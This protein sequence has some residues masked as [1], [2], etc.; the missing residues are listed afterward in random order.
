MRKTK[1]ICTIGPASESEE[2][3]RELM[4]AG[5]D[6]ARLNFSHG[7][8]AEQLAKIDAIKKVRDE[9][10]L[11]TAILLDTKGPEIRTGKFKGG[12]AILEEG[13]KF[14]L[15]ADER[16]GDS[17]GCSVTYKGLPNDV[18][19]GDR[20]LID[21]G[22]ISLVADK[23][24]G[25]DIICTVEN[26]GKV[27]NSKGINVPSVNINLPSLTEK[28]KQ[29][30]LFGIENGVDYIAASFIRNAEDVRGIRY[31]LDYNG[32][33]EIRII[34]KIENREGLS[35]IDE[36]IAVSD[37]IMVARGDLGV[38]IPEEDVPIAQK[39]II[40][41]C[42]EAGKI[43]VTATQMLDSMMRN[44]RPTRAEI[45]DVANAI[46][47]G[48][49]AIMLSGETAS[50]RYPAES[51]HMMDKLACKTEAAIV[52]DD[53]HYSRAETKKKGTI[54]DTIGHCTCMA[55]KELGA[56]AILTPTS[57]GN[58]AFAV[59]KFRPETQIIAPTYSDHVARR[60]ALCWGTSAIVI[61]KAEHQ[62]DVY[63]NAVNVPKEKGMLK[64][65]DCVIITAGVPL[66]AQGN[67]NL[68]RIHIVGNK[69][70]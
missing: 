22:L 56:K 13:Q 52:Y 21:D 44:P 69:L 57:S 27:K 7:S 19:S 1:I 23:V 3:L 64:D 70:G 67:T 30:L 66:L 36:I 25:S 49:D 35:N 17:S 62:R 48:T 54:T 53:I 9:L 59:A 61:E 39:E 68:M 10:G 63:A 60:L 33:E 43:V 38:E 18:K 55:A 34:S 26:S 40:R 16:I 14:T 5:M 42:N 6:V 31:F 32:G 28:D 24:S 12:E 4:K 46:F 41:K 20:I 45:T 37:G 51:V 65:G 11:F 58:T 15:S 50:G 8:R 2:M 47:D 29:D